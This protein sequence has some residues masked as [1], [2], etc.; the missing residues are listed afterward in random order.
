MSPVK[1]FANGVL[2]PNRAAA[3]SAQRTLTSMLG[4]STQKLPPVTVGNA[5][6][7]VYKFFRT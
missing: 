5:A 2:A 7:R 1:C 4:F 3:P 6:I